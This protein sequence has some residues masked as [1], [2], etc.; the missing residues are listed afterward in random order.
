MNTPDK[1]PRHADP[2]TQRTFDVLREQQWH[3]A[4]EEEE[5]RQTAELKRQQRID[6]AR[7]K[8]KTVGG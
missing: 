8:T 1:H 5:R 3:H 2:V 6:E 7:Q 4:N